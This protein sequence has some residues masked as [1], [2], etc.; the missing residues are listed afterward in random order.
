MLTDKEIFALK[1]DMG[2]TT[3]EIT[4]YNWPHKTPA[5]QAETYSIFQCVKPHAPVHKGQTFV[6]FVDTAHLTGPERAPV[7]VVVCESA[8]ECVSAGSLLSKLEQTR[9]SHIYL[10]PE[11]KTTKEHLSTGSSTRL[12]P[13]LTFFGT[14]KYRAVTDLP[15][16][17]VFLDNEALDYLLSDASENLS[18]PVSTT[19][20]HY[21]GDKLTAVDTPGYQFANILVE[22]GLETTLANLSVGNTWFWELG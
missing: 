19:C 22:E 7:V 2:D 17:F 20:H 16:T 18:V 11:K 15:D 5:S 6:M 10:R 1:E 12:D 4:I 8:S 9:Y 3:N 13:L 21:H 14:L